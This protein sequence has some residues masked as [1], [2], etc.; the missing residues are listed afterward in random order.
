M[1]ETL[2]GLRL[3]ASAVPHP[4]SR[5][6]SCAAPAHHR[7]APFRHGRLCARA[8]V[9]GPP[10]VDEDEAMSIDNLCRFFDLNVGK[11]NGIF[12]VRS[13]PPRNL[14]TLSVFWVRD[15]VKFLSLFSNSM[16]TGGFSRKSARGWPS[17]HTGRATSSASCN[18]KAP[19]GVFPPRVKSCLFHLSVIFS[20]HVYSSPFQSSEMLGLFMSD[21]NHLCPTLLFL[22]PILRP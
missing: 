2:A 9:A 11:W 1:A 12:Y 14:E 4:R 20:C 10:E 18:R 22:D 21:F 17:V 13:P 3:A 6:S 15:F 19:S 7:L 5:R 16:R 8:A